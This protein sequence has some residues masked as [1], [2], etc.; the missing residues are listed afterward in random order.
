MSYLC[1]FS[2]RRTTGLE[3]EH[4]LWPINDI[5][6][7]AKKGNKTDIQ[8]TDR[9]FLALQW[10]RSVTR[11]CSR[12]DASNRELLL[13]LSEKDDLH[14]SIWYLDQEYKDR[15]LAIGIK[16]LEPTLQS[17]NSFSDALTCLSQSGPKVTQ[18]LWGSFLLLIKLA[19]RHQEILDKI[20]QMLAYI[21]SAMPRFDSYLDLYP[22]TQLRRA[23][24]AIHND[25]IEFCLSS[26]EFLNRNL[27]AN[28]LRLTWSAVDK[29]FEKIKQNLQTHKEEF[30]AEAQLANVQ[31]TKKWQD[32]IQEKISQDGSGRAYSR[33]SSSVHAMANALQLYQVDRPDSLRS[34]ALL[35][36]GGVGKTQLALEYAYRFKMNYSHLFWI[37]SE[38]EI[39]LRQ[40]LTELVK[41]LGLTGGGESEEKDLVLAQKWLESSSA[42]WLLI[43]DNVQHNSLLKRYWPRSTFGNVIMTLKKSPDS[44]ATVSIPIKP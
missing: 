7:I 33:T 31:A 36:M 16:H 15:G 37:K 24:Y 1:C 29:E 19:L 39:E 21:T 40:S 32:E 38:T 14:S 27:L 4:Q 18:I 43:F 30:E 34:V 44:I 5:P 10:R 35:G 26:A 13:E 42:P 17:I 11:R 22:T 25:L 12:L 20:T 28:I 41:C 8:P 23:L 3:P 9:D 2:K 6:D